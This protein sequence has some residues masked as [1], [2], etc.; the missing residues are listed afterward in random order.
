MPPPSTIPSNRKRKAGPQPIAPAPAPLINSR[1]LLPQQSS[2]SASVSSLSV[3]QDQDD[4]EYTPRTNPASSSS[5]RSNNTTT[6]TSGKRKQP[7][8]TANGKSTKMSREALR[9]AN[10][11]LIERRRREK[12]NA[13]LGELR[14]MVPGLGEDGGKAGEFKLEVLERTVSHMKD[15]K[16]HIIH[17]EN[18]I[19][20]HGVNI[21]SMDD[22]SKPAGDDEEDDEADQDGYRNAP[23]HD[24]QDPM[25]HGGH[26]G[27]TKME[28]ANSNTSYQH[29][30]YH[31][32]YQSHIDDRSRSSTYTQNNT[33][34]QSSALHS[35]PRPHAH[36]PYPSPRPDNE[37]LNNDD[38]NETEPETNLPPPL[39]KA[40]RRT[41][42]RH[43][44]PSITTPSVASLIAQ[45]GGQNSPTPPPPVS[46]PAPPP[47]S[48]NPIFLPFPAPSPTSPF[49]NGNPSSSS[50]SNSAIHSSTTSSSS[51]VSDPSPFL[52]P[53]SG[54][55]LFGGVLNLDLP[56][57]ADSLS[58]R[59]VRQSPPTLT[60]PPT[61]TREKLKDM[62]PEEAA[63]LLLAFS[64]PDTLRPQTQAQ[65]YNAHCAAGG[66]EK[67]Q[68]RLTLDNDDFKLDDSDSPPHTSERSD[69]ADTIEKV[70]RT[71]GLSEENEEGG[72]ALKGKSAMDILKMSMSDV[73]GQR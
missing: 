62:P 50:T 14:R 32:K 24:H 37:L 60:L 73:D 6:S 58:Q 70:G 20:E 57:P 72:K 16:S 31:H 44:S 21:P 23:S 34:N 15:L 63:N 52:A 9:K 53:I 2:P 46:R 43:A 17:L 61:N 48:N 55:S 29:H 12:I 51:F 36:S 56:S 59:V 69:N 54:M 22:T 40:L 65:I 11:S 71:D 42:S 27:S 7:P 68:R 33:H 19:A 13:A 35:H 49:M 8:T 10:H 30:H 38:P 18:I 3:D 47:Q 64:S 28:Y 5:K 26:V 66:G 1:H 41:I 67:R 39:T 45:T 4:D 25:A